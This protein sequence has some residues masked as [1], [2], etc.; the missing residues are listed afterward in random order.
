M[1]VPF[2]LDQ[3]FL[4]PLFS[5]L[6]TK[7]GTLFMVTLNTLSLSH[8]IVALYLLLLLTSASCRCLATS[9]VLT[10]QYLPLLPLIRCLQQPTSGR[11]AR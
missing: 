11:V 7:H 5:F 2:S 1:L 10:Q 6:L 9:L 4:L 8:T 3:F